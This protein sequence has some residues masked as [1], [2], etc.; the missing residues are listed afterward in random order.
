MRNFR[1]DQ[2]ANCIDY[3][4]GDWIVFTDADGVPNN[5]EWLNSINDRIGIST[6]IILGYS[7]YISNGSLLQ[8]FIQFE[9]FLTA[10]NYLSLAL[11]A[12]PYMGVGRNLVI[13]KNFFSENGGY[14]SFQ[15]IVGANQVRS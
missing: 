4:A 5:S 10:F 14:S 8:N 13:K 11:F 12:K 1:I 15:H 9:G 6:K 7:P 3:A 2:E